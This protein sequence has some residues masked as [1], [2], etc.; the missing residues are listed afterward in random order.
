M[1]RSNII[2]GVDIGTSAIRVIVAE[3]A[4]DSS[5]PIIIGLGSVASIGLRKGIIVDLEGVINDITSCVEQA[6]RASGVELRTAAVSINGEHLLAQKNKSVIAISRVDGEISQEDI[7]RALSTVQAISV[8]RNRQIID[9]I[10]TGY[11]VDSE[12][13]IKDPAGMHGTKLEI[14]AFIVSGNGAFVKNLL[15]CVNQSGLDLDYPNGLIIAP[16]AAARA[17]LSRRQKE[18]G[19]VLIDIGAETTGIAVYEE[20]FLVHTKI[21]PIGGSHITND[22]A[23][24]LRVSI[25]SA[26][27]IKRDFGFAI[28][29]EVNKKDK[30]NLKEYEQSGDDTFISRHYLS[31]IIEARLEEIFDYVNKELKLVGKDGMLP[32]GAVLTGGGIKIPRTVELGKK[33]LRLPVKIGETIEFGGIVDKVSDPSYATALG[34][35]FWQIDQIGKRKGLLWPGPIKIIKKIQEWAKNFLP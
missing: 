17:V 4:Q 34:L 28:S 19:V 13:N 2:V 11:A 35:I 30:I 6:E 10:P 12:E 15:K 22:I 3:L 32:E 9:T 7:D 21:I 24:G 1:P 31:Q 27:K 5:K 33:I 26:E 8:S 20:G 25:D 14:N 16:L 23:I 29:S 18:L